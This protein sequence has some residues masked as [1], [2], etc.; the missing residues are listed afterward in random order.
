MMASPLRYALFYADL[1]PRFGACLLALDR[2][3]ALLLHANRA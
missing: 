3:G 2:S 1:A